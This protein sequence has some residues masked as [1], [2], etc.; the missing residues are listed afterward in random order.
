M[1][2]SIF[3][4]CLTLIISSFTGC[5][6]SENTPKSTTSE[7]IAT[8]T[9]QTVT[10]TVVENTTEPITTTTQTPIVYEEERLEVSEVKS[11]N[12]SSATAFACVEIVAD[13]FGFETSQEDMLN[14]LNTVPTEDAFVTYDD[15]E[16]LTVPLTSTFIGD[17]TD[18]EAIGSGFDAISF[19]VENY[20]QENDISLTVSTFGNSADFVDLKNYISEEK[21][22]IRWIAEDTDNYTWLYE[23][24][25]FGS[26]PIKWYDNISCMLLVGAGENS[27]TFYDPLTDT[28]ITMTQDEYDDRALDYNLI[29]ISKE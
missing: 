21:F 12:Y 22:L 27:A 17:P 20:F 29:V 13:H 6:N 19:A 26:E 3:F 25:S 9:T 28:E 11:K 16:Y 18:E 1:K 7:E 23:E 14:Y 10:T 5:N 24:D 2:K 15:T 8:T 4:T